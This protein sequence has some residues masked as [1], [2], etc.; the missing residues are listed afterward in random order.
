MNTINK[1]ENAANA[2]A[3][4][5]T[6]LDQNRIGYEFIPPHQIKI[7]R[8]NFWPGR[9]TITVDG[10]AEKRPEKGLDGL[11]VILA[12]DAK[13][14]VSDSWFSQGESAGKINPFREIERVKIEPKK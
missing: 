1:Q 2:M 4:A 6:W 11:E 12:T 13:I 9:G 8:I 3:E 7:G 10:E 5:T 14:N